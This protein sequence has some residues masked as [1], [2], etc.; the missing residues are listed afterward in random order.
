MRKLPIYCF[1]P[2]ALLLITWMSLMSG[3]DRDIGWCITAGMLIAA[4]LPSVKVFRKNLLIFTLVAATAL[5]ADSFL[6]S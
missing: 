1:A 5:L 2:L 3:A 6:W 4:L